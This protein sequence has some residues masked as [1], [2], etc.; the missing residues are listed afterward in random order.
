M[1]E[2]FGA[3]SS[4]GA[5]KFDVVVTSCSLDCSLAEDEQHPMSGGKPV[6]AALALQLSS[7]QAPPSFGMQ[8]KK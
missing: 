3:S 8:L 1:E 5:D 4:K 7:A 6:D 2:V